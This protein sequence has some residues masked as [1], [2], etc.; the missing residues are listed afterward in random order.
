MVV[1][2]CKCNKNEGANLSIS[3]YFHHMDVIVEGREKP[4]RYD[5]LLGNMGVLDVFCNCGV[6]QKCAGLTGALV[7]PSAKL[8][9]Q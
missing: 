6:I 3:A 8:P 2:V 9:N 1:Y 7:S 4:G 5:C